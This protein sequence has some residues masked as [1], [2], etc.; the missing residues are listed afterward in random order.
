VCSWEIPA[1]WSVK[2]FPV[3]CRK[4]GSVEG[5]PRHCS[6]LQHRNTS[7]QGFS[8]S[9]VHRNNQEIP[10]SNI[11]LHSTL[12]DSIA[13]G[14]LVSKIPCA[15]RVA[16]PLSQTLTHLAQVNTLIGILSTRNRLRQ[17]SLYPVTTDL[18]TL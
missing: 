15:A 11:S 1:R 7:D 6:Y 12:R 14:L 5:K 16:K 3:V 10:K 2:L 17:G 13:A 8:A 4:Q 18:S 9:A